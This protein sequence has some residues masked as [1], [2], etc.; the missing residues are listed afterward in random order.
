MH[1]SGVS[2]VHIQLYRIAYLSSL[3]S[4]ISPRLSSSQ[5]ASLSG[6]LLGFLL[7]DF[8]LHFP[9]MCMPPGQNDKKT[10]EG[11]KQWGFFLCSYNHRTSNQRC[12][13]SLEVSGICLAATA[14]SAIDTVGLLRG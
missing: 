3:L 7:P 12:V 5:K 13:L 1:R 8:V 2:R 9:L 10:R 4:T 6:S 11:G 14:L